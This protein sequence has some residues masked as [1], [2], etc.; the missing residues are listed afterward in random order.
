MSRVFIL[1]LQGDDLHLSHHQIGLA[2]TA[3]F[4]VDSLLFAPVGWAMVR[5]VAGASGRGWGRRG[6]C[7][8]GLG[9][10]QPGVWLGIVA[11]DCGC[12]CSYG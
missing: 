3:G 5:T 8:M 11:C 10:V 9:I 7:W 12:T 1:P 2:V 4:V 6:G